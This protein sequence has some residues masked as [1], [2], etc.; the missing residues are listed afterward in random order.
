MF[1]ITINYEWKKES[2]GKKNDFITSAAEGAILAGMLNVPLLYTTDTELNNATKEVLYELG[3]E[4]VNIVNIGNHL[5]KKVH[6]EINEI[7]RIDGNYKTTRDIY[8]AIRKYSSSNDVIFTRCNGW[9]SW[10]F[11]ELKPA[12]EKQRALLLGPAAYLA[13]HHG[14]PIIIIE[15]HP[16]LSSSI[17]YHTQ[18]WKRFSNKRQYH[19]PST[20]EMIYTGERVYEFL[21]DYDF[22]ESGRETIITVAG[23]YDIGFSWDR[24]FIGLANSGRFFGSPVDVSYWISRNEFYPALIFENPALSDNVELINGSE[25]IRQYGYKIGNL[26]GILKSEDPVISLT[27]N[28]FKKIRKP[29]LEK[30]SHP[31]LCSFV[32]YPHRLNERASKYYQTIYSCANG[33]TPSGL[34]DKFIFSIPG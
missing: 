17:N 22:D 21:K 12:D 29:Q 4:N 7:V 23:Q 27:L 34:L 14:S 18:L 28:T 15:N 19:P 13:A 10:Y 5:S 32:S 31:V 8:D 16:L 11:D 33:L 3:V 9:T 20:V 26:G 25:S 30:Y 6:D 1:I 2:S 24:M